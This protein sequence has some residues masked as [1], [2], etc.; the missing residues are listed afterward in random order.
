[1][2]P[3]ARRRDDARPHDVPDA[4]PR[5]LFRGP[6]GA[7]AAGAGARILALARRAVRRRAERYGLVRRRGRP[8]RGPAGDVEHTERRRVHRGRV[9]PHHGDRLR[10]GAGGSAS[11]RYDTHGDGLR[12]RAA[13]TALLL[14]LALFGCG[15]LDPCDEEERVVEVEYGD[16]YEL[17][18]LA[19][20][21]YRK[22]G[23]DCRSDGTI[24][25]GFG[26]AIGT[27][28]VCTRCE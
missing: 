1:M 15:I 19:L 26:R 9:R 5:G 14:P 28:Y 16:L 6:G 23:W 24:R 17:T 21:N 22:A 8:W 4:G 25:D 2:I 3:R 10:A 11:R 18:K 20:D 7:R 13:L 27:R 12:R